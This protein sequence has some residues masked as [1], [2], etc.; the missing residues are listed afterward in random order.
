MLPPINNISEGSLNS[1][2]TKQTRVVLRLSKGSLIWEQKYLNCEK[3]KF[4]Q[5]SFLPTA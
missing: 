2:L 3:Y 4:S 1:A 5:V